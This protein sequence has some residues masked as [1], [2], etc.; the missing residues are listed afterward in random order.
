MAKTRPTCG[1]AGGVSKTGQPCA[2]VWIDRVT[3][4]CRAHDPAQAEQR[5]DDS[6]KGGRRSRSS[7]LSKRMQRL[8]QMLFSDREAAPTIDR[9]EPGESNPSDYMHVVKIEG[10]RAVLDGYGPHGFKCANHY[11]C[12]DRSLFAR[13][14]RLLRICEGRPEGKR[15]EGVAE[16]PTYFH[17][18]TG[19]IIPRE[20]IAKVTRLVKDRA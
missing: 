5:L 4:L 13:A 18:D 10:Q 16:G 9:I 20:E 11:R 6:R 15:A 3:H 1:E 19:T 7:R 17:L 8:V 14:M 2:S 12:M